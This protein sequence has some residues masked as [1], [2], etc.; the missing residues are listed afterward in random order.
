[1]RRC[2]SLRVIRPAPE[3][4]ATRE[5][6]RL[7]GPVDRQKRDERKSG[8]AKQARGLR[9]RRWL[10]LA[11]Y[12]IQVFMSVL[13]LNLKRTVKWLTGLNLK[14]RARLGHGTPVSTT[15]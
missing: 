11:K 13:A 3:Q 4:S 14:D 10:R 1:V 5:L 2:V 8:E 9:S 12:E 15:D 7:E 6:T